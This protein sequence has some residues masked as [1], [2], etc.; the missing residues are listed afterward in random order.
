MFLFP[1]WVGPE[2]LL[3]LA[4]PYFTHDLF[5]VF[6]A[7]ILLILR[8]DRILVEAHET[9]WTRTALWSGAARTIQLV[10][11]HGASRCH[12][13]PISFSI[14]W[15]PISGLI[16]YHLQVNAT[17]RIIYISCISQR[18]WYLHVVLIKYIMFSLFEQYVMNWIT[19]HLWNRHI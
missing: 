17:N 16:L 14:K 13:L 18:H 11:P 3:L 4:L 10:V 1:T 5:Y 2:L 15:F 12:H 6:N 9:N 7:H 19:A 8:K